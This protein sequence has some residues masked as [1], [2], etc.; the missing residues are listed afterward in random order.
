MKML[1]NLY[2][3]ALISGKTIKTIIL[4]AN[5]FNMLLNMPINQQDSLF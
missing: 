5:T 2:N 1:Y 4:R 3:M